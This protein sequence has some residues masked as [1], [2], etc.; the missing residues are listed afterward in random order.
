MLNLYRR[1]APQAAVIL[2][3]LYDLVN[4]KDND[5]EAAWTALLADHHFQHSNVA[6]AAT[7]GASDTAAG[8]V[9]HQYLH[10]VWTPVSFLSRTLLP[11]EKK[12]SYFIEG[13]KFAIFTDHK[14]LT[15]VYHKV[16]VKWSLRQQRHLCFVSVF[17]TDIRCVPGADNVVTD[18]LSR[19][20]PQE[21]GTVASME[22]CLVTEVINYAAMTRNTTIS[23][24][25]QSNGL[26]ARMHRAVKDAP[27]ANL[28]SDHNWID[29][30]PVVMLGMRAAV[31]QDINCSAAEMVFGE[32][33]R[34][35]GNSSCQQMVTG[36][37]ILRL[38]ST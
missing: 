12:Y 27:K 34:L 37:L 33:L 10:G 7:T 36:L 25:R 4:V 18:A 32:A 5:F 24:H 38:W 30:L 19:A 17:T 16:S 22:D 6:L 26:V 15:F 13:R 1:F 8:T 11:A 35:P 9:L 3:P 20:S 29:V 23:Y 2:L 31:K 14:P 21:S 28:E